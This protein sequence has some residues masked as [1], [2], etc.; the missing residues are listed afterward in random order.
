MLPATNGVNVAALGEQL[1]RNLEQL[2]GGG[3]L[4]VRQPLPQGVSP[5]PAP[6]QA[7]QP[8]A[9][10]AGGPNTDAQGKQLH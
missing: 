7:M 3:E 5:I 8:V 1:R 4:P 6:P 2:Q 10:P 9:A